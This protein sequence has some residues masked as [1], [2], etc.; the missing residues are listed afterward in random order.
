MLCRRKVVESREHLG[1]GK[2]VGTTGLRLGGLGA[3]KRL[4]RPER[5][6]GE[7]LMECLGLTP[8]GSRTTTGR[9]FSAYDAT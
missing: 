3:L 7:G 1:V 6:G 8:F 5:G 9:C 4:G 2:A